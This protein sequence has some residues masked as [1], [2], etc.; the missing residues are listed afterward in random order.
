MKFKNQQCGN[1]LVSR[2]SI[3]RRGDHKLKP[4]SGGIEIGKGKAKLLGRKPITITLIPQG[5]LH[6]I[7]WNLTQGFAVKAY[8]QSSACL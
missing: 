1:L 4:F 5:V 6:E 2:P 8:T 3:S 7:T